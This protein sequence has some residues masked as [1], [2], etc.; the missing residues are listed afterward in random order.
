MMTRKAGPSDASSIE[1]PITS[2]AGQFKYDA[3][4]AQAFEVIFPVQI[5]SLLLQQQYASVIE[6]YSNKTLQN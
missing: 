1:Q 4:K 2:N 5:F 6:H 3:T